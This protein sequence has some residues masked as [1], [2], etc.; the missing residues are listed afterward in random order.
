M[1]SPCQ[2]IKELWAYIK[3]HNLQDPKNKNYIIPDKKMA[4]V[5]GTEKFRAF[6]KAKIHYSHMVS[7]LVTYAHLSANWSD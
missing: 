5:F 2:I 7:S 3:D 1:N 4:K 6:G